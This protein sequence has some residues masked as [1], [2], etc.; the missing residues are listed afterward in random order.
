MGSFVVSFIGM[1]ER[2]VIGRQELIELHCHRAFSE[3][4]GDQLVHGRRAVESVVTSSTVA[5][6]Q[7]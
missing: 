6:N 4:A 5:A 1:C 7:I 2:L 3:D